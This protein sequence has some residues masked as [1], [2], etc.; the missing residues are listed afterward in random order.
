M[1]IMK[2]GL[3]FFLRATIFA[4]D[5]VYDTITKLDTLHKS[6]SARISAAAKGKS[7]ERQISFLAYLEENPIISIKKTCADLG[8]SFPTVSRLVDSF[9]NKGILQETTRHSRNRVFAYTEY[10]DILR[11]DTEP[12]QH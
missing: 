12:L 11:Q 2:T 9:V 5:N 4:A 3:N 10:L 1:A 7:Q 6:S 8:L